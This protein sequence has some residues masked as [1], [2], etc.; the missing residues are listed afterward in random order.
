MKKKVTLAIICILFL[1]SSAPAVITVRNA[2]GARVGTTY[3]N[4][5]AA[6]NAA[7]TA[8]ADGGRILVDAV[9]HANGYSG[10]GNTNITMKTGM[11]ILAV[12]DATATNPATATPGDVIID[13]QTTAR[14]FLFVAN[15]NLTDA[16]RISGGFD[17]GKKASDPNDGFIVSG[18][19]IVNGYAPV[20][21][22]DSTTIRSA[23]RGSGGG[24]II[25]AGT[26]IIENCIF[27]DCSSDSWVG[28]GLFVGGGGTGGGTGATSSMIRGCVFIRNYAP[29]GGGGIG[30]R[31]KATPNIIGC[32]MVNNIADQGAGIYIEDSTPNVELSTIADNY[33]YQGVY[34]DASSPTFVNCILWGNGTDSPSIKATNCITDT[35]GTTGITG[36][37]V[38]YVDP[39]FLTGM[40]SSLWGA[41]GNYYLD[42]TSPAV[43]AGTGY[44]IANPYSSKY[45]LTMP[46]FTDP[47][48]VARDIRAVDLG[49]HYPLYTGPDIPATLTITIDSNPANGKVVISRVVHRDGT[50]TLNIPWDSSGI[51]VLSVGDVVDMTAEPDPGYRVKSWLNTNDDSVFDLDNTG[52]TIKLYLDE[53]V[54][55]SFEHNLPNTLNYPGQ[56]GDLQYAVNVARTGDTIIIHPGIYKLPGTGSIYAPNGAYYGRPCVTVNTKAITIRSVAP[57]DPATVAGT[58]IEPDWGFLTAFAVNGC[59]RDTVIS[60]LTIRNANLQGGNGIDGTSS[61]PYGGGGTS[62]YGAGM[63]ID[64]SATVQNCVFDNCTVTGGNGGNGIGVNKVGYDGGDGGWA[65]GGAVYVGSDQRSTWSRPFLWHGPWNPIFK[66]VQFLNCF[67]KGGNGGNG[68]DGGT[69]GTLGHGG[70]YKNWTTGTRIERQGDGGA[71]FIHNGSSEF[72]DCTFSGAY[73][74]SGVTGT[75]SEP[76]LITDIASAGGAVYVGGDLHVGTSLN[77]SAKFT[78]CTFMNNRTDLTITNLY[79]SPYIGY[80]GAVAADEMTGSLTLL[81]CTLTNNQS[82]IGGAVY[83]TGRVGSLSTNA[84]VMENNTFL[85]NAGLQGG[86]IYGIRGS[87]SLL[88]S[89]F[90]LN[91]AKVTN[92][93]GT[94]DPNQASGGIVFTQGG[95]VYIGSVEALIGDCVFKTNETTHSGGALAVVGHNMNGGKAPRIHNNLFLSNKADRDGG[96]VVC[97]DNSE[98]NVANCT[99]VNNTA[100]GS[101]FATGSGGAFSVTAG[102]I[103]HIVNC[104][105]WDNIAS[106]GAQMSLVDPNGGSAYQN[107][108]ADV[109]Y[110]K[111][112]GGQAGIATASG[113]YLSY[114]TNNVEGSALPLFVHTSYT[115][116]SFITDYSLASVASGQGV[117]SPCIDKGSI[118]LD[119]SDPH[120][121]DLAGQPLL[122]LGRYAY[123]LRTDGVRDTGI[124]D[125]GYHRRKAGIYPQ[126]DIDYSGTVTMADEGIRSTFQ[127]VALAA[128]SCAYPDWCEGTDLNHDSD[129]N[130]KD[131]ALLAQLFGAGDVTAPVPNPSEWSLA[132]AA[133]SGSSITM[134]AVTAIDNSGN[135]VE[136]YFECVSG[137]GHSRDWSTSPSYT[138]TGLTTGNDYSYRVKARDVV[139]NET[140]W[141]PTLY[142]FVGEDGRP[143]SPNPSQWETP[144]YALSPTSIAMTA[145]SAIDASGVQYYFRCESGTNGYDS[146]WQASPSFINIGLLP[147]T[148]Y[149]Y[150]VKTRD[151]SPALNTGALSAQA[152]ATT[153][154]SP[155]NMPPLPNPAQWL[156]RP[157]GTSTTTIAMTAVTAYDISGVEYYFECTFGGHNHD[158]GWQQQ[159]DYIATGLLESTRYDFL[160]RVRDRSVARN[161]CTPSDTVSAYTLTSGGGGPG[162]GPGPLTPPTPNPMTWAA[163]SAI[164][165]TGG[166]SLTNGIPTQ[167]LAT[168]TTTGLYG[169]WHCMTAAKA[170]D[171]TGSSVGVEYYFQCVTDNRHSS[172]WIPGDPAA[173]TGPGYP[174]YVGSPGWPQA[175]IWRCK[176]RD[177]WG[178]ETSWSPAVLA[179][180]TPF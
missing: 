113:S 115:D 55:C 123:T 172:G 20:P 59:G 82:H 142:A 134:T 120:L 36:T 39:L 73:A 80:G 111:I 78:R 6:I 37:N 130:D 95:A 27:T 106:V 93:G 13:C 148:V 124:I 162:P 176:A 131:F 29:Y 70:S 69:N 136:Y 175:Y 67:A 104:L 167:I 1:A 41:G 76:H 122:P 159:P 146:G 157:V 74:E 21:D 81:D 154:P 98:P 138:D 60:G 25:D 140:D 35:A 144:P 49:Y 150:S 63:A 71:A 19:K 114:K 15:Q 164:T 101:G 75:G 32:L 153:L 54:H 56:Y 30:V 4:I 174:V 17:S 34:C 96:A 116:A 28:G 72:E 177:I 7:F 155:D 156:L 83:W 38:L 127:R 18:F 180:G 8:G 141:S 179:G 61:S 26:P 99:L 112:Q 132:P 2:A 42:P 24:I 58:V 118:N 14:A 110:C 165:V 10:A 62:E 135:T 126:G 119:P 171:Y 109:S 158:S 139:H 100:T 108:S 77:P 3:A 137:G 5:Q 47:G 57:D 9:G 45:F 128:G 85:G 145:K 161:E 90:E 105:L 50:S 107:S 46:R 33:G 170:I 166:Q 51:Y 94:V 40:Y 53:E 65:G 92:A 22:Q 163:T 173:T 31:G 79:D 91:T 178:N 89:S 52:R 12:S 143:P 102:S 152:S 147:S 129:V 117:N 23:N 133:N 125:I 11:T 169:Y 66:N 87:L 86:A 43:D 64:G 97:T 16:N 44:T 68:G 103:T 151:N 160:L 88:N 121:L 84:V 168:E 149:T 48:N